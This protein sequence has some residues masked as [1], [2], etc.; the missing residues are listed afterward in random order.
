[1]M[2]GMI[3]VNDEGPRPL[4][5]ASNLCQV[6]HTLRK[7]RFCPIY[8][9]PGPSFTVK[10]YPCLNNT[11]TFQV[12]P[13]SAEYRNLHIQRTWETPFQQP[14]MGDNSSPSEP[15]AV[16]MLIINPNTSVSMTDALKPM[17]DALGYQ[18]VSVILAG[19]EVLWIFHDLYCFENAF[20]MILISF[21]DLARPYMHFYDGGCARRL[22]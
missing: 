1:M 16:R 5:S 15:P 7:S 9:L 22:A 19:S 13:S 11:T 17:I 20:S 18:G 21:G 8:L 10:T 4:F 3:R 12:C 2:E 14:I 6:P